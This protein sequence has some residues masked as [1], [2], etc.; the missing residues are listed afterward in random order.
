MWPGFEPEAGVN[1]SQ[2]GLR[3]QDLFPDLQNLFSN[4][5]GVIPVVHRGFQVPVFHSVFNL[6]LGEYIAT[7]YMFQRSK[8]CIYITFNISITLLFV[9]YFWIVNF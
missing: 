3:G 1:V 7:H 5:N 2:K 8:K 4:T 9:V 6:I